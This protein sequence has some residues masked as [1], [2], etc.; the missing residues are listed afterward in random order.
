M[1]S[2]VE[3]PEERVAAESMKTRFI[4]AWNRAD[5][6]AYGEGY[7]PDAELVDPTGTI[8]KGRAAIAQM[9]VDLWAGPFQGS[10]LGGTVRSVRRLGPSHLLVDLDLHLNRVREAPPG[11]SLDS[12][13]SIRTRL[14]HVLE[15]RNR[16]WRILSAQNT[17]IATGSR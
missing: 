2:K 14:K 13:G 10:Q 12:E 9:H 4:D 8:W 5:G 7:W 16:V 1:S 11:A 15:E 6:A 3:S 17:F